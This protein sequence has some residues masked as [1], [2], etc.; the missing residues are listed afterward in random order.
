MRIYKNRYTFC[1]ILTLIIL[2]SVGVFFPIN[3]SSFEPI[4][5]WNDGLNLSADELVINTPENKTYIEPMSGYYPATYGFENDI[6]GT[7]PEGWDNPTAGFSYLKVVSER[8]GRKNVIEAY[9][10]GSTTGWIAS[11]Y[12]N[13]TEGTIEFWWAV[14]SVAAWKSHM[15]IILDSTLNPLFGVQV[16]S[17][18]IQVLTGG[19]WFSIPGLTTT[20]NTWDHVRLDFRSDSGS[21]YQGMTQNQYRIYYNGIDEGT[22]NFQNTGDPNITRLYS[23][24]DPGDVYGYYDAISFSWDPNYEIGDNLN[25]GLLLSFENTTALDWRGYSLDGQSNITILGNTTIQM[26]DD[27]L[28]T[29]QVS[30]SNSL[31]TTYQSDVRHFSVD[32]GSPEITIITPSQNDFF[33]VLA[34]SFEITIVEP[35]LNKTWYTLDDGT[36]NNTFIGLTGTIDQIEWEK[37]GMGPV[38]IGFYA[39][40]T[41]GFKG[42]AE[43]T[44]YKVIKINIASPENRTYNTSMSGYYLSTYG[45]EN[46][47]D[48]TSPEGWIDL[49]G[50]SCYSQIISEFDGHNK[51]LR[52]IDNRNGQGAVVR[53]VFPSKKDYGTIEYYTQVSSMTVGT[54]M[55]WWL[56]SD[57][58]YEIWFVMQDSK[59]EYHD[60]VVWQDIISSGLTANTWYHISVRW[61]NTG[62][63]V[64]EGLNEG[65]WKIFV[66]EVEY[67]N[68]ALVHDDNMTLVNLETGAAPYGFDVFW[69][70]VGFDWKDDYA[71]GDNLNE[72]L[73]VSFDNPTTL[74]WIGYSLD[75]NAN[76]TILGNTTIKIPADGLHS[77]QVFGNDS[78]DAFYQSDIRYFSIDTSAPQITITSPIQD[79]FFGVSP[80]SFEI[81]VG[82]L[83]LNTTWYTLDN[84]MT[85]KTFTGLSGTI[86]QTLWESIVADD[87]TI[88]FYANDSF[89]Y[90]GYAEVVIKK[91]LIAPQSS[92]SNV[93]LTFTITADDGL[94]SGV[95]VIRYKINSSA[96]I[97]YTGPFSLD[98]G[99]YNITY[100]AIDVVDNVEVENTLIIAL[101]EPDIVEDPPNWTIIIITTS[102]IGG[103][104]LV[105]VITLII[106]KHK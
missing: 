55:N 102:I 98:Y 80:P 42:Y 9:D 62:A 105:I 61:R 103:I 77:I 82:E 12:F 20:A 59:L 81:I 93:E 69:D 23:G 40:D 14:S 43:V 70:A 58:G 11:H 66:D 27:G 88:R 85:N 97:D 13:N 38:T 63:P 26:P 53:N 54:K 83:N 78:L 101:N 68:Y 87:I 44:I 50:P 75:G 28:H 33:G 96:W 3:N 7:S 84:G 5:E 74:D 89:G 45:F 92:I 71:I 91:D 48:G 37:K 52:Q 1:L 4:S 47:I 10:G 2:S 32:T 36:I 73:L 49:D 60:G 86:E 17:G 21:A 106:R 16:L 104:G 72:G 34:P 35:N 51:V 29:I 94:G 67:G 79:D 65:E 30:G 15:V 18:Q 41:L 19:I 100:Q 64:Y 95:S 99:K 76:K 39:N 31:G 90:E 8:F 25:E 56:W 6:D 24:L 46:D 57:S 22:Y